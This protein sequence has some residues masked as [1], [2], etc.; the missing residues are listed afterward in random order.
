MFDS[1]ENLKIFSAFHGTSY[2]HKQFT[3]RPYHALIFKIDGE[4]VYRFEEQDIILSAGQV[5]FIPEGSTYT[6]SKL[7][8]AESHYALINFRGNMSENKP[9]IFSCSDFSEFKHSFNRMEKLLLS[10]DLADTLESMSVF[11]KILSMLYQHQRRSYCDPNKRMLIRPATEYLENHI[12][13]CQLKVSDLHKMCDI[14]DT[15][16]RRIFIMTYGFSPKKYIL[17]KRLAQAKNILD[18]GDYAHIYDVAASVGFVDPL[19]FSKAFKNTYG[20]F[21]SANIDEKKIGS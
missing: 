3:L 8:S 1:I 16:F 9:L 13:D 20:Y 2:I 18:S 4:S 21:P 10:D 15:Y 5:L 12:F 7:S 11:Y 6:V 17:K 14:S 19:Y